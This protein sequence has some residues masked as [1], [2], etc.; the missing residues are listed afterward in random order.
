MQGR[1]SSLKQ[2]YSVA[3]GIF[4]EGSRLSVMMTQIHAKGGCTE[5]GYWEGSISAGCIIITTTTA[6]ITSI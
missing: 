2:C 4:E 6:T 5:A 3:K 1:D